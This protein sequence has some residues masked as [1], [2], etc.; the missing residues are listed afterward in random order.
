MIG[1]GLLAALGA[2]L[3]WLTLP[4]G[5]DQAGITSVTGIGVLVLGLVVAAIGVFIRLRPDHPRARTA[6][7]AGLAAAMGIGALGVIAVLTVD[8]STG[9][10]VAPGVL[11]SIGGG[12]VATMGIR[13]LLERR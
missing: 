11:F 6:A 7:W 8:K 10:A 2:L 12:M 4:D 9:V 3:P 5:S 1:G 13:G